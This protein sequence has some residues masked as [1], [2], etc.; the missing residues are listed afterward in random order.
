MQTPLRLLVQVI[1]QTAHPFAQNLRALCQARTRK[2]N[3]A[4]LKRQK[5][6]AKIKTYKNLPRVNG[7][8]P[9]EAVL[10]GVGVISGADLS[11]SATA[12]DALSSRSRQLP[13][14]CAPRHV[15]RRLRAVRA[16]LCDRS[17]QPGTP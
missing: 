17:R 1:L 6:K 8:D 3:A 11:G 4:P 5:N 16:A 7:I 9:G 12:V 2:T 10:S 13:S 14:A 15:A